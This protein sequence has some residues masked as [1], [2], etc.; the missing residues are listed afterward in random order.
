MALSAGT[1][2]GPYEIL[3]PLGAGGMGEVYR[4]KDTKLGREVA[5][6]V[7]PGEFFENKESI[8]RFERE[9]KSLAAVSHPNIA[10][11]YSFEEISGRH[12]LVMELAEGQTL[13]ERLLKGPL[14]LDQLLRA[15]IEIASAL[16]AAHRHGIV[17]RDL[18][19]GNVM[20]TKPGVKLLDF[21]L[22][23]VLDPEGPVESLTSAPTT[24]K[25]VTREGT[26]LGTLSYMAP[27]QLEGKKADPRTD[28]FAF[29][30]TLYEMAT[31]RKAFS[32]TS[33]ASLIGA[34]LKDE[35]ALLSSIQPMT[36]PALDRV[37]KTCLA[38]DPEDRWQNAG[39]V[40]KEL[41]WIAEGPAAGAA[42]PTADAGRQRR[43]E[44][45]AWAVAALALLLGAL[46]A[47][48]GRRPQSPEELTRFKII[49]PPGRSFFG[50]AV[51][52]PDARRLLLLLR[53]DGGKNSLAVRSL[54]SLDVRPLPGTDDTRGAFWSPD[55]REVAFFAD[56]K[57]KRVSAEGGPARAVCESEAAVWGAWSREGTILFA[58]D[59]GGP[60]LAVP[61]AGGAPRPVTAIDAAGGDV[62]Q[63]HPCLLPDGRHFVF[64]AS[65][66]D[67][68]KKRILLGSLD[69]KE[70][71]PLF[72]TDSSAVYAEPGYLL[73]ARDDAVLAWRF[74][75]RSLQ[76]VGEPAPAFENV[77]W[78]R[79]DNFLSLSAAGSRV[80]YVS[81]SLRRRLAWVDRKGRELGSLGEVG[82][83]MDV[84]ISPDGRRVAVALRDPSHGRNGDI[85]VLDAERGIGV[86]LTAEPTD[87][88]NPAWFPDSDRIAYVSDRFG[89]Y[90]L[91]ERPAGGGPEK[92]LV[93]SELDKMLPA[94]LADG[95]HMLVSAVM[96]GR[97]TRQ[98]LS[99]DD[100]KN[101]LRLGT[102]SRFSEEHP[103]VS[104]DG[105]WTAFDSIESGQREVYFQPVP[106]GPKRQVSVGGGQMPV[107]NR[108]GRELFYAA[109]DGMLMSVALRPEGGRLEAG[110][111][112]PLFPLQFDV[113]GE[114][115]WHLQPYDVAPDG[116]RF[117]VIRRAPGVDPDGVVVVTNWT[118]VLRAR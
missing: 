85:W 106:D 12:L 25:D 6:K 52:S 97:Y 57:L 50:F 32:G 72:E 64:L 60:I 70:T 99:L 11:L 26:I 95:R 87:E 84:R 118:A 35:P 81:W 69:S 103:V 91:F 59:F 1:R 3:S 49:A 21:G 109:R 114:L 63:N 47:F 48:P 5:V 77:H 67:F 44:R 37:V 117:L 30:A 13:A 20:L 115:S 51:L 39:D 75:P 68:S 112:Q 100:P 82:G 93:R 23:K 102:D 61:A 86:R 19:P 46:S 10:A 66:A 98:I 31:G 88:L 62:H 15:G 56:G 80:A 17:H 65:N 53:D 38:K 54:D 83:Y 4:A 33:Q 42:A 45:L 41:K 24:A 96:S 94:V 89:S 105:R 116:Q 36:P 28:I 108:S 22:A 16:D 2:L 71:R 14:P 27:E 29:G 78:M 58:K 73:F 76:L 9:A 43:R 104:A 113:S 107:W 40:A 7:L 34:I 79:A 74:D 18:K 8:A 55:S 90:D 101:S 111:P 110:E 92:V